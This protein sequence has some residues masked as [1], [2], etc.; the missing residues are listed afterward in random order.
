MEI[1]RKVSGFLFLGFLLLQFNSCTGT[2]NFRTALT[3][4]CASGHKDELKLSDNTGFLYLQG[5]IIRGDTRKKKLA[6]VFTGDT[7]ADGGSFILT[8]LRK[9]KIKA[10]FFLTGNFYRNRGFHTLILN[11]K[12]DGHYLGSHSDS[13]LLYCDWTK[14]D[15]LLVTREQFME[16]L[17]GSYMELNKYRIRPEEARYFLPPYEWYNDSIAAWTRQMCLHLVNYTPGTLSTADYTYPEM[18]GRYVE[19]NTIFESIFNFEEKSEYGLNGFILLLH[20]GTDPRRT[21][22]FYRLLPDLIMDIRA[23][24]YQFVKIDELLEK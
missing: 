22:K 17:A 11:L 13:H 21:E 3:A 2:N 7:F 4:D 18:Q 1:I 8:T 23:R 20:I 6:L 9:N 16:D 12:K 14:R 24:G 19:N 5:A 15:S 10:S